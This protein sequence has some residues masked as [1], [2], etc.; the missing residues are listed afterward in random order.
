MRISSDTGPLVHMRRGP[1]RR[2]VGAPPSINKPALY[3][4][5]HESHENI[6]PDSFSHSLSPV[7][8]SPPNPRLSLAFDSTNSSNQRLAPPHTQLYGNQKLALLTL[9]KKKDALTEARIEHKIKAQSAQ[10]E[11]KKPK[12][13]VTPV[14]A[15]QNSLQPTSASLKSEND[16]LNRLNEVQMQRELSA[17][18][19]VK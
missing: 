8:V 12:S 6:A 18:H 17:S 10:K 14:K 9:Q 16:G 1:A 3:P 15:V 4:T 7:A 19:E 2:R 13:C 11:I 5:F